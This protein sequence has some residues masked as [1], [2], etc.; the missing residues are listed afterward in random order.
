M[1]FS[2]SGYGFGDSGPK[3]RGLVL[4]KHD[5]FMKIRVAEVPPATE[6]FFWEVRTMSRWFKCA[7]ESKVTSAGILIIQPYHFRDSF[8][9]GRIP[10]CAQQIARIKKKKGATRIHRPNDDSSNRIISSRISYAG[11]ERSNPGFRMAGIRNSA[12]YPASLSAPTIP[13]NPPSQGNLAQSP[14]MSR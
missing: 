9:C 4:Q 3:E 7:S 14:A 2:V 8:E 11:P 6:R 13:L 10:R 1:V 12:F 5:S